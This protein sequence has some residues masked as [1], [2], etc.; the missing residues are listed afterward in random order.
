M[1]CFFCG[2]CIYWNLFHLL[3]HGTLCAGVI[4]AG[5]DDSLCGVGVAYDCEIGGEYL[6]V[7]SMQF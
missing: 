3:R 5:R 7:I 4:A 6:Y 1:F 2:H